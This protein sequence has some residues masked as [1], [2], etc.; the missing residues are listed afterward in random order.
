MRW[1]F[2]ILVGIVLIAGVAAGAGYLALRTSLPDYDGSVTVAGLRGPVEIL[3]DRNA[4]PHIFADS[5]D[6]AL[7]G[8]GYAHAQDRLWQMEM[9]RRIGH[10]RLSEALGATALPLD[11]LLRAFNLPAVAQANLDAASPRTRAGY[12]AYAR[13]VNAYLANREGL[14]PPEFVILGVDP[15]PWRPV[16]SAVWVKVMA[17]NLSSSWF[18][19]LQRYA[20][21]ARLTPKQIE[22]LY[23]PDRTP[24]QNGIVDL[25]AAG[26]PPP[27]GPAQPDASAPVGG[28]SA[29]SNNWVVDGRRTATGKP[30]LAN[31]PHL[32]LTAPSVWY[33]AHLSWPGHD[34]IGATFPGLPGVVLGRNRR[35]AWGF[36]NTMGD[37][38]DLYLERLEPDDP[39]RYATPTGPAA[40]AVREERIKV[41]GDDDEV[42]RIRQTRHGPVISDV[43]AAAAAAVPD[44]YVLALAWTALATDDRTLEAGMKLMEA[45]SWNDF[46]DAARDYHGP[47]Q[48]IV[49]ADVEGNTGFYA[50]ARVPVRGRDNRLRGYMPQPGWRAE[51]DWQGFIPFDELPHVL[52][53]ASGMLASANARIVN[54]DY[55]YHLTFEWEESYRLERILAL[56]GEREKHSLQSFQAMQADTV[57]L[58]ARRLLPRM[59]AA[60]QTA[61]TAR[62]AQSMLS[63]WDA[64]MAAE[65]PEPLIFYA[66]YRE[67]TRMIYADE[68]GDRFESLWQERP[69]FIDQVL[70]G[71]AAAWCDDVTTTE[72]RE[73]CDAL[74]RRSLE[75]AMEW[76]ADRY[77]ADPQRWRWGDAHVA[78]GKHRP[79]GDVGL[80]GHLFDLTIEVPGGT[81]TVN[82]GHVR[83]AD[84]DG[85]FIDGHGPSMR[86]IYDL[87]DP[88]RSLFITST[89]QSG[90]VLSPHYAD[91]LEPWR[92]VHHL[93]MATRRET[94][95]VGAIGRLL[96]EP[97]TAE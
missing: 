60:N 69:R 4:I 5:R 42:V 67:L 51:F 35:I 72:A 34:V 7:F 63:A 12:E 6:D 70:S 40:F 68:L 71:P 97:A 21:S 44:G 53:P 86:A 28:S 39:N 20:L 14:L 64:D 74:L 81:Y 8:L 79:F 88:E 87:D 38:Q 59:L 10:G 62:L 15:A 85:P 83:L 45:G 95:S 49:Y 61:T 9:N 75:R 32:G 96:L 77:G 76:L 65:R 46:V 55:P 30:L 58:M 73:T 84:P 93:P 13:G 94:I 16:D 57:S 52:N 54:P 92:D 17:F 78:R 29:A 27:A 50:P 66:W 19:E 37:V 48:N 11:R 91:Y 2:G 26:V 80:L 89:G 23:A 31:D 41:K 1:V 36:T 43:Y 33:L 24:F 18:G 25:E 3:R 22:Q 90:N 56:L 47:Q 82:A